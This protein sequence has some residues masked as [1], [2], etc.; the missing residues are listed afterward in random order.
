M[1]KLTDFKPIHK[2]VLPALGELSCSG[3]IVV[4]GPNS[5]GKSQLLRDIR[6]R[7]S[8]EPRELVV[9]ESLE[10]ENLD[11]KTFLKCLKDE[12]YIY[13]TWDNND[14]EQ[15]IPMTTAIGTGQGAQNVGTQQLQQWQN[16]SANA[17]LRKRKN[18]YFGW[19]SRFLVTGLFL[20][21]RL[22]SMSAAT[23]IDFETQPPTHDLH[24]LHLNDVAQKELTEEIRRA[25]SKAIWSDISRGNQVCLRVGEKGIVPS[26]EERLSVKEMAKYRTL[27]SEGDGM[28]SYVAT[29][30]SLLLGRRPV[31]VIDE[32]EMCLHPPQAYNLGQFIG[33]SGTSE[34]TATFVATHS[35][36]IL[37]GVLQTANK[38][39]IVR[40]TRSHKGFTAKHLDSQ[41]LA[42]AMRKPT[43][44]AETVLDGI[45]AQAV[46]IIEADGDRIVYQAAWEVVGQNRNFDIHFT[47]AGGTG[48]IADTSQLY[49]MLG[50]PVAVI[51][52]LDLVTDIEKT[53]LILRSLCDD[54]SQ[55]EAIL[56]EARSISDTLQKLPPTISAEDVRDRLQKIIGRDL[57]WSEGH[58]REL[59]SL[60]SHINMELNGMRGLKQGGV[61][62][63]P[64]EVSEQLIN[65]LAELQKVGLFLV[66][67][68]EL[69]FWLANTPITASKNKKWAWANE[70][71]EFIRT[72]PEQQGDIWAFMRNIGDYLSAQFG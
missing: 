62:A 69:E 50:I 15:Y 5:S 24:A 29:A 1:D 9:A 25:F 34:Q 19:F 32:P 45:F 17:V 39:Q 14:Q 37:R 57:N 63:L 41:L 59:R 33:K 43:V 4:V 64:R 10:L 54:S 67:V 16:Q 51:A 66:P 53:R 42:E 72:N 61:A 35:S 47:A 46:A 6:E 52:D 26:A 8:G 12:G 38:L 49:K 11:Y 68:G 22:T 21:N 20:E 70:A 27:A 40:M 65:H 48:G 44:R 28:K 71:S 23:T 60:L 31:S 13:S 58:D 18:E 3:L 56:K 55:V 30:I 2:L 7:I 36:Q